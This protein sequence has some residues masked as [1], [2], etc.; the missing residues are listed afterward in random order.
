ML[1]V[2]SNLWYL[3]CL[4]HLISTRAFTN[5]ISLSKMFSFMRAHEKSFDI[6]LSMVYRSGNSAIAERVKKV[7]FFPYQ[8]IGV[9]RTA[10]RCHTYSFQEAPY[11]NMLQQLNHFYTQC[12]ATFTTLFYLLFVCFI[13]YP[14]FA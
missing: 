13:Y 4:R 10:G 1:D 6:I 11:R 8:G 5:R 2:S 14:T 7:T 9:G 3:T 12:K